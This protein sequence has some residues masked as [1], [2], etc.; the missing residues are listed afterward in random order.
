MVCVVGF[1][2]LR[3]PGWE[4]RGGKNTHGRGTLSA[5][6]AFI[7]K[8]LNAVTA[9]CWAGMNQLEDK[10]RWTETVS[11]ASVLQKWVAA[12]GLCANG[13]GSGRPR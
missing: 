1:F 12:R 6:L 7:G 11:A 4:M 9:V 5:R 8:T 13:Q 10:W 2:S 3:R